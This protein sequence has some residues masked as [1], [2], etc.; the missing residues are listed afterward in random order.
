MSLLKMGSSP[1]TH[2]T[3]SATLFW[4]IA[5]NA[6]KAIASTEKNLSFTCIV[7]LI[8]FKLQNYWKSAAEQRELPKCLLKPI[9]NR[10]SSLDGDLTLRRQAA[11]FFIWASNTVFKTTDYAD[12]AKIWQMCFDAVG[13]ALGLAER[14]G[15]EKSRLRTVGIFL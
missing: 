6:I 1:T 9:D 5:A 15:I 4:A 12:F 10:A 11:K 3:S 14:E 8:V 7:V 13:K 2:A